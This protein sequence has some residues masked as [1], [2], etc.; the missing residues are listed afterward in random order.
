MNLLKCHNIIFTGHA[1][2]RMFQRGI[3]KNDIRICVEHGQIIEEYQDDTPYP[4][5]LLLGFVQNR[6]IH[7]VLGI[8]SENDSCIVV[9]AY[10][11]DRQLWGENFKKRIL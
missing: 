1:V 6:P 3:S 10:E 11:P 5:L 4:S 8:D 9:T 7:I 2:Q